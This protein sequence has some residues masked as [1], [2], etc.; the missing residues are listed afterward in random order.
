[1]QT[2]LHPISNF[3]PPGAAAAVEAAVAVAGAAVEVAI[4][5][6]WFSDGDGDSS[7]DGAGKVTT[8]IQKKIMHLCAG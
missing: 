7:D 6:L 1:M 8:Q 3:L 2:D 5:N 4:I